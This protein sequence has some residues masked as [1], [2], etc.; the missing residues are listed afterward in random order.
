[1]QTVQRIE[2]VVDAPHAR[3]VIEVLKGLGLEGYTLIRGVSGSGERGAQLGDDITG[4]SN[5]N[6]I[7]TTCPPERLDEVTAALRPLLRRFGGIC[8]VSEA[9]WL[10]H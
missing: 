7:L 10:P 3:R 1:L 2:I 6:Y 4:V 9:R 8:L 5:N